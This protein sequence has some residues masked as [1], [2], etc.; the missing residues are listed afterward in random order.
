[1]LLFIQE[2]NKLK[3]IFDKL[4]LIVA[5]FAFCYSAYNLYLIFSDNHEEQKEIDE[6]HE[7]VDVPK[8]DEKEEVLEEWELDFNE[9]LAI[10][11]DVVGY[12]IVDDTHISYPIVKGED[13]EFYLNH[14]IYGNENYAGSV[15]MDYSA[16]SDFSDLNTFIYAH[17]LYHGTMFAELAYYVEKDFFDTHPYVH[18]YTPN[19]NYKLQVFSAY[20]DKGDSDSYRMS[21]S[22]T[23]DYL[24]YLDLIVSKSRYDSGVS[25]NENDRIITLYTCSFESENPYENDGYIE[26][27]YFI[28]C[29]LIKE[30]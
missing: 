9:L 15:F 5:L 12:I 14:S 29:K 25:V 16:S 27:R 30:F 1:M 19:G 22:G 21:F 24:N 26:D 17:N 13:N 11:P 28:H 2:V 3:K 7:I 18:L 20:V 6:I 23:Q 10:N 4:I 8:P